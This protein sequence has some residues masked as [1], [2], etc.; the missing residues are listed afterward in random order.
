MSLVIGTLKAISDTEPEY[1][2]R[3]AKGPFSR[4]MMKVLQIGIV[5]QDWDTNTGQDVGPQYLH[6]SDADYNQQKQY[7]DKENQMNYQITEESSF[8]PVTVKLTFRTIAEL[9]EFEIRM[10]LYKSDLKQVR[11]QSAANLPNGNSCLEGITG[12][13]A[14]L[15]SLLGTNSLLR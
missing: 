15:R 3:P 6:W 10:D 9:Q 7:Y 1:R 4:Y 2:L 14:K 13:R 8:K 12:F 11:P 5:C